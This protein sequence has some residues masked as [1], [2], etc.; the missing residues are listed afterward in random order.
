MLANDDRRLVQQRSG[1]QQQSQKR[2][3]GGV[4]VQTG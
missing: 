4:D 3:R 2:D 1:V